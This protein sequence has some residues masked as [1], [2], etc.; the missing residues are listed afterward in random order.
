MVNRIIKSTSFLAILTCLLWAT[1]FVGI[2]I[3]LRY[4]PPLQFA[5]LRFILSGLLILPFIPNCKQRFKESIK[6]WKLLVN[7]SLMQTTVLY[8]LFY[9]GLA[10]VPG[11]VGAMIVGSNPIFVA[12]TAHFMLK[13]D[14]MNWGKTIAVIVGII[15]VIMV[16]YAGHDQNDSNQVAYG[17]VLIGIG[18]LVLKNFIG[19]Y[20]NVVIAKSANRIYPRVLASFSLTFGGIWILVLSEFLEEPVWHLDLPLVFYSA[21]MWLSFVSAMA[22]AIWY[23]LLQRP[24]VKVS[25]LNFW[26]FIIP[27]FGALF[28][29]LILPNEGPDTFSLVGMAII[30]LSLILINYHNRKK[31]SK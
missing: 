10:M 14:R 13:D 17:S 25:V 7:I 26:T 28:S 5:G 15:G 12:I 30:A 27:I 23:S 6:Y 1:P 8:S 29:W 22:I 16:S 4:M 31:T 9:M 2:K 11:Y 19:S 21:W 20:G 18:I 24:E 3:G